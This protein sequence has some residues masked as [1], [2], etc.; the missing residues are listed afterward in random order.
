MPVDELMGQT[1]GS[2]G[3]SKREGLRTK[4]MSKRKGAL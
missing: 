3:T 1:Q 2:K 4:V